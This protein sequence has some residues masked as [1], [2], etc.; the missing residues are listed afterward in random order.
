M[1]LSPDEL[2]VIKKDFPL[3]VQFIIKLFKTFMDSESRYVYGSSKIKKSGLIRNNI[4]IE[5]FFLVP[6]ESLYIFFDLKNY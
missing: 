2:S 4:N 1:S 6:S 3:S 5:T